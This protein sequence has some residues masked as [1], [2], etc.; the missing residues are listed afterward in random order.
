MED[1]REKRKRPKNKPYKKR[2]F[3]E[4]KF[5]CKFKEGGNYEEVFE[6]ELE[7]LEE[8]KNDF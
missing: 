8:E 5:L 3:N 7:E 1:R 6:E 2:Q 4:K